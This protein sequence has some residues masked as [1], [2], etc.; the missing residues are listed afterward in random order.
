MLSCEEHRKEFEDLFSKEVY[1]IDN[2]LYKAW[3]PLKWDACGTEEEAFINI[4]EKR[5]PCNIPKRARKRKIVEPAG[6]DKYDPLSQAWTDIYISKGQ[7]EETDDSNRRNVS[8]SK[9]T[10]AKRGRKPGGMRKPA[11]SRSS[12]RSSS[13]AP[14]S[15]LPN[16]SSLFAPAHVPQVNL[17]FTSF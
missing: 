2:A 6:A 3:L 7:G 9:P 8:L 17:E 10:P 11:S 5:T 12:S 15:S 4:I 14:I 16:L 13:V 1:D